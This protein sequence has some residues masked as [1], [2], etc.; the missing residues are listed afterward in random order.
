MGPASLAGMAGTHCTQRRPPPPNRAMAQMGVAPE[1]SVFAAHC[2][3][4]AVA[5]SQ[6]EAPPSVHWELLVQPAPQVPKRQMGA[7]AVVQL[8]FV[9]HATHVRVAVLQSGVAV[10]PQSVLDWHCTHC[11][12]VGSHMGLAVAQ[13]VA[14]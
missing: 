5:M 6:I 4:V 2:T 8:A 3:Q 7:A 1:Q 10:A 14:V 13:F 11:F 9:R 12:V